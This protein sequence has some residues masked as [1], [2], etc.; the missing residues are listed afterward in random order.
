MPTPSRIGVASLLVL[1][2]ALTPPRRAGAIGEQTGRIKGIVSDAQSGA[3]LPGATVSASSPAMIGG[4]RSVLTDESGRYEL[5]N[6]PP[7]VYRLEISYPETVPNV[8]TVVVQPGVATQVNVAWS[9]ESGTTESVRIVERTPLTRPDST[10]A[11]AL[12][13]YPSLNKLPTSRSYQGVTQQVAGVA[14]DPNPRDTNPII[15]GGLNLHN[16]YLVDGL[17]VTDPVTGTFSTNLTFDSI[18][19]VDVLTSGMEAQYNSLGGVINVITLSGSDEAHVNASAYGSLGE[20]AAKS[21]YG[22]NVYDGVQPFNHSPVPDN[23]AFQF[24]LTAGGPVVKQRLW[25]SGSYELR[26]T[27]QSVVK[28]PPLGVPPFDVQH[29]PF[30]TTEHL[31]RVKLTYAP[32]AQHRVNFAANVVTAALNNGSGGNSSLGV[33]ENHQDIRNLFGVVSWD[34]L[35]GPRVSTNVRGGFLWQHLDNGPQGLL[36]DVDTTGCEKFDVVKNCTYDPNRPRH[37]NSVDGTMWYQGG[38]RQISDRYRVQLDPSIT[39]RGHLLGRHDAKAGMQLEYGYRFRDVSVPGEFVF[40]DR[41]SP[42][43]PLEAGL[44]DP[45]TNPDAC[46][47]RTRTAPFKSGGAG[48]GVGIYVQDRWWT[49]LSRLTVVPGLRFDWGLTADRKS[50]TVTNLTGVAPRLGAI[51]DLT[52][53]GRAT[54]FAHY[55]RHTETLSLLTASNV[56]F[57]ETTMSE[58]FLWDPAKKDFTIPAGAQGGATGLVVDHNAKTP[59]MDE[60]SAGVRAEIAPSSAVE[61]DYTFRHYANLWAARE[62]NIIWDPT[63][64]RIVGWLDPM[65]EGQAVYVFTTPDDNE[66]TYHGFDLIAQGSPTRNWDFGASYTLSWLFGPGN[67]VFGQNAELSQY[68]NSRQKRFYD[69]FLP[70]DVRHN[71]KVFG[72]YTFRDRLII[73]LNFAYLT[74]GPLTKV[75]AEGISANYRSP[76]GTEP[77]PGND[78]KTISEFR[79]PDRTVVDLRVMCNVLPRRFGQKLNLIAD[80]FNAFNSQTPLALEVH[81]IP[82]FGQATSTRQPPLRVQLALQYVY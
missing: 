6:L 48:V 19:A 62:A 71:V 3:R 4:A 21:S 74:G 79:T 12:L 30:T 46:F 78:V 41:T 70:G 16:H 8:R 65:K 22:S 33:A 17:D 10:Q 35:G 11:G 31:G 45:V 67:T 53:D 14:P 28:A 47:A 15:K 42:P 77:G 29:P 25:V 49:P 76:L 9:V 32:N 73:G 27:E 61:L 23:Q 34:W 20:L 26:L 63:G 38:T 2:A 66:R 59:H 54:A 40:I 60:V 43:R 24:S 58:T 82:T 55:G 81:D 72:S 44:C 75:Y 18:E 50:R 56:D 69:G 39:L 36:G 37:V 52:G 5:D 51:I 7:G 64:A 13:R 57:V 68:D 80:L 1:L